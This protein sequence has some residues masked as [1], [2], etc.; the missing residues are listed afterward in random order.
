MPMLT[1]LDV[2]S[3]L[4]PSFCWKGCLYMGNAQVKTFFITVQA[5]PDVDIIW[6]GKIKKGKIDEM[7]RDK[8]LCQ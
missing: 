8:T 5:S 7:K 6:E 4:P 2:P 1:T 3:L